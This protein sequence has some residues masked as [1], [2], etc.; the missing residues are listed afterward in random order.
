MASSTGGGPY[1][2]VSGGM[3][4]L[5]FLVTGTITVV[6]SLVGGGLALVRLR[7]HRDDGR[8]RLAL[9]LALATVAAG[10]ALAAAMLWPVR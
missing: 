7:T 3:V 6:L 2:E 9:G 8:A 1:D 5:S 10:A 4:A